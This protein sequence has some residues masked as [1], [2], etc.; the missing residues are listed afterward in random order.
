MITR[1]FSIARSV[2]RSPDLSSVKR[3]PS[4]R[5]GQNSCSPVVVRIL[6]STWSNCTEPVSESVQSRPSLQLLALHQRSE[7][8]ARLFTRLRRG[9]TGIEAASGGKNYD[10]ST[11]SSEVSVVISCYTR[12]RF[13][14][15]LSAID[16]VRHQDLVPEA[17]VISVDHEPILYQILV[18]R[19]PKLV[20]VENEFERGA[21]G[22]RNTGA[23]K[24]TTPFIAFLDDDAT[25][26]PGWL[27]ALIKPFGDPN[28]VCTGGFAAPT[29]SG[30][31]PS[32]FPDE[33]GWVVGASHRGLPTSVAKVRN[34]WSQNMAVRRDVFSVVG[35]FRV[36]FGKIGVIPRPEDTDLC[37]RMGKAV[38]NASIIFVPEAIVDHFVG[39]ERARYRFFLRRCYLEGRG[40]IELARLNDG[41]ADLGDEKSYILRTMP[42]GF[43]RYARR[44][45]FER[46]GSQI[47]RA[48]AL[49]TGVVAAAIG[50]AVS[51]LSHRMAAQAS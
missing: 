8:V 28:V 11:K 15:L 37:I 17:I 35:G 22:N 44:G 34:V 3:P 5:D 30:G 13:D 21:S 16:S 27:S 7:H 19:F 49:V 36:G 4:A 12:E 46:D 26:R 20:V 51:L 32:W 29:W 50:A 45:I 10:M 14:R 6:P 25:A 48:G 42:N 41:H 47:R 23:S 43:I 39:I 33:F 24:T 18:D 2:R 1:S 31:E 38:S 40:K 9:G